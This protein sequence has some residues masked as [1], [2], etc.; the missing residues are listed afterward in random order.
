MLGRVF[1]DCSLLWYSYVGLIIAYAGDF[2]T[3][4]S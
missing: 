3:E 2:V 4:P 1:L